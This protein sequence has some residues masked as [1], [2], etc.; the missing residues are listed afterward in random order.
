MAS[1]EDV[2]LQIP[3]VR[4]KKGDGTLYIMN[5]RL[6]WILENKDKVMVSHNFEDVKAQKIS[7]EGKAKVQ[8]QLVLHNG[9]SSI[10]HFAN[11]EGAKAQSRDRDKV[12]ELLA[13]LLPRF[14]RKVDKELEGKN[15]LLSSNPVLFQIYQDLVI[16]GIITS[17]EFWSQYATSAQ[18]NIVCEERQDIGVSGAFLADIKP[19]TDGCNGLKY[20][21]TK[22]II[23]CIFKTYPAVNK[24]FIENVP[25]KMTEAEF[26]TKFFQ[27]HYF[28][29]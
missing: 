5:R 2:I 21:I 25:M 26:W 9:Q 11:K 28:H 15:K 18:K 4:Y 29:R 16:T 20:N 3:E 23:E 7:P 27:S 6:A 14:K 13:T 12:K 19:Q 17:E 8:L 22:E 1:S 10:F 24:K